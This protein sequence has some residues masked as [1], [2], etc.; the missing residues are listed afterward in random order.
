MRPRVALISVGA[1]NNYGHPAPEVLGALGSGGARV[2]RT[3]LGGDLAVTATPGGSGGGGP[4][5]SPGR[6]VRP[7]ARAG[8]VPSRAAP[9]RAGWQRRV[10][11]VAATAAPAGVLGRGSH[12]RRQADCA[13]V[14]SVRARIR[15]PVRPGHFVVAICC[16][17]GA[18]V[19]VLGSVR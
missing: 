15:H 11:L 5:R 1:G 4:W 17:V 13:A 16:A 2:L 10:A 3:D 19:P 14:G 6:A 8:R 7:A 9:V 18:G 12:G